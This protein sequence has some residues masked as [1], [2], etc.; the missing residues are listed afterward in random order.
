M[1]MI[2]IKPLR[3][4]TV[5]QLAGKSP[6]FRVTAFHYPLPPRLGRR[7]ALKNS[8]GLVGPI[9]LPARYVPAETSSAAQPLRLRQ[10]SLALPQRLF[11]SLALG[12]FP[13][14]AQRAVH[15]GHQP[16]YARFQNIICGADLERFNRHFFAERSGNENERHVGAA[17]DCKLQCR[18]PVERRKSV[19]GQDQVDAAPFQS[20]LETG[21]IVYARNFTDKLFLLQQLLH[22]FRVRG[23][24]FQQQN[25]QGRTNHHFFILPGGGSLMMAQKT[26]SSRMAFT[27]SWKFTGFTTY[28]FTPS[29]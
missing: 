9:N 17:A 21:S 28:P 15:G 13:R 3:R 8:K 26:P 16:G 23:V 29:L 1:F 19:I 7:I 6:V 10:I 11:R 22:Q 12:P 5:D 14:F 20:R 24:I 4:G 2:E 18:E 25:L 27:N